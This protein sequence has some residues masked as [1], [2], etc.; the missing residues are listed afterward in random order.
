MLAEAFVLVAQGMEGRNRLTV[1]HA[2]S[3]QCNAPRV[4]VWLRLVA[5]KLVPL[6]LT[7]EGPASKKSMD[8]CVTD[9]GTKIKEHLL[10]LD[11]SLLAFEAPRGS[12]HGPENGAAREL[13]VE[14]VGRLGTLYRSQRRDDDEMAGSGT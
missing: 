5:S 11:D 10:Q 4:G 7:D 9:T 2:H 13:V 6:S 12:S 1:P 3:S 8:D 14:V